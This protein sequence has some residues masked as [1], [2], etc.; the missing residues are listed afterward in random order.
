VS[1]TVKKNIIITVVL[2]CIVTSLSIAAPA[3]FLEA[4]H[5]KKSIKQRNQWGDNDQVQTQSLDINVRNMNK[6]R[7]DFTIQWLFIAQCQQNKYLWTYSYDGGRIS[8]NGGQST[9]ITATSE[10]LVAKSYDIYFGSNSK[11]YGYAVVVFQGTNIIKCVANAKPIQTACSKWTGFE[12]LL[13]SE[14]PAE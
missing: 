3:I 11:P 10:N 6:Y 5:S 4:R 14:P 1:E 13:N 9:N 2:S 8:L 12:E 7:E